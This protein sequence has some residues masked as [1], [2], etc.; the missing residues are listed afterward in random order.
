MT[1]NF[2][3]SW[4]VNWPNFARKQIF[5]PKRLD[6]MFGR[7]LV[8]G[9]WSFL[10]KV[11]T[12]SKSPISLS[13]ER[14][15]YWVKKLVLS[16]RYWALLN[17]Y[18]ATDDGPRDIL[19][20]VKRCLAFWATIQADCEGVTSQR[21]NRTSIVQS[22]LPT[23]VSSL[24]SPVCNIFRLV[25]NI[26]LHVAPMSSWVVMTGLYSVWNER[27]HERG[28]AHLLLTT[29]TRSLTKTDS[30]ESDTDSHGDSPPAYPGIALVWC[31]FL[32]DPLETRFFSWHLMAKYPCL[33]LLIIEARHNEGMN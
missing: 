24:T 31:T 7:A 25:N 4:P 2:N 9:W 5:I 28:F 20:D 10:N 15:S 8:L 17:A 32:A 19:Q 13:N 29:A 26:A 14:G 27:Y 6:S 3:R 12:S 18:V 21:L 30:P 16:K 22:Y 1:D 11:Y 33:P 23:R